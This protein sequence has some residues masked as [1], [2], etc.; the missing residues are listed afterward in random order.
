MTYKFKDNY[1]EKLK[2]LGYQYID[3][4]YESDMS[5]LRCYDKEGYIVYCILEKMYYYNH[6]PRRFDHNNDYTT[7]NIKRY[8]E[9]NPENGCQY[10]SGEY[11]TNKSKLLFRCKCGNTFNTTFTRARDGLKTKCDICSGYTPKISLKT[12]VKIIEDEGYKVLDVGEFNN[13]NTEIT[14]C[15]NK[16]YKFLTTHELFRA[17]KHN[18]MIV[19]PQNPFSIYNINN[20][21]KI[22]NNDEYECIS[23][24]FNN[25]NDELEFCHLPCGHIIMDSWTRINKRK[26]SRNG[27][28]DNIIICPFCYTDWQ[29]SIH[30]K[31]L[32]QV[33]LNEKDGTVVE[34]KSCINP[35]TNRIMPTDIVNHIE[36][37]AI[38]VQS[39]YHDTL[40]RKKKDKIKKEYWLNKGY[41]MYQV[42]IRDYT[43]LEMIQIFFPTIDKIPDY[44]RI[45]P[46]KKLDYD[47]AQELLNENW[48]VREIANELECEKS[49]IYSAIHSNRISFIKGHKNSNYVSVVKLD[50]NYNYIDTYQTIAEAARS[51]NCKDSN[52][53]KCM[54]SSSV[55]YSNGY[56]WIRED[57]YLSGNYEKKD[58]RWKKFLQPVDQYDKNDNFIRHYDSI[59]EA[60]K[61]NNVGNTKIY[62]VVIGKR[63]SVY[64]YKYKSC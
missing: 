10:V 36:K 57:D 30:A 58:V 38:E 43:I 11:K 25:A 35:L 50:I 44:V 18:R 12:Q 2:E 15:D 22:S 37:V 59:I 56:I 28:T 16:G 14:Y 23:D 20:F 26:S 47:K 5:K 33:W 40:E 49:V 34:D 3:G 39:D 19:H 46:K 31:I 8:F 17:N 24:V 32:K 51:V 53:K 52:I 1:I 45:N 41:K 54:K 48:T 55:P 60:G 29:E 13:T 7:Y 42:D 4:K 61:D 64:G 6:I 27:L 21:L 63:K 62:E 9:L